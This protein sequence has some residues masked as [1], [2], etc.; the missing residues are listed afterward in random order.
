MTYTN[1]THIKNQVTLAYEQYHKS[2]HLCGR[3]STQYLAYDCNNQL[4]LI[5]LKLLNI[6][7]D[8]SIILH[9]TNF[10]RH[11]RGL[12][13]LRGEILHYLLGTLDSNNAEYY[14]TQIN[15]LINDRSQTNL[16]L[17]KQI[18]V[19]S[20]T[21][22]NFNNSAQKLNKDTHFLNENL[23]KFDEFVTQT[24]DNEE[25]LN[26]EMQINEY[27]LTL[28]EI[29]NKIQASLKSYLNS[30]TLLRHGI[31]NFD[32]IQPRDLQAEL[33]KIQTTY[34]Y[35]KIMGIKSFIPRNLLV[36]SLNIPLVNPISFTLYKMY[37][38]PTP[39]RDE[40]T[41]SSNVEPSKPYLLV[42]GTKTVYSMLNNLDNCMEYL[43]ST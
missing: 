37:H 28:S 22:T 12:V 43:P 16:L 26:V 24:T 39:H 10:N 34:L 40:P 23:Q 35:Y 13:N 41:L 29:T 8:L 27:I 1:L 30:I 33:Q 6:E 18:R 38:L 36:T 4:H 11:K 17:Q 31:I 3:I 9:Q 19:I 42:S 14:T 15:A 25:R 5:E 7:N 21:I 20:S 2:I 32:I